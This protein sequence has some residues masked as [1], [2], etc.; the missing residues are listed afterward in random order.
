MTWLICS[1]CLNFLSE[2]WEP[3]TG[4]DEITSVI[5]TQP[6]VHQNIAETLSRDVALAESSFLDQPYTVSAVDVT[7]HGQG[8]GLGRKKRKGRSHDNST[9]KSKKTSDLNESSEREENDQDEK[10]EQETEI[11]VDNMTSNLDITGDSEHIEVPTEILET[12]VKT[13]DGIDDGNKVKVEPESD[14]GEGDNFDDG[15]FSSGDEKAESSFKEDKTPKLEVAEPEKGKKGGLFTEMTEKQ[16]RCILDDKELFTSY[17]PPHDK[18]CKMACVPSE[19]SDQP[20]H[21]PSLIRVFTVRMKK[22]WVL[23]YPLSAQ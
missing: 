7:K 23:S 11:S 20:R 5:D 12:V 8:Q 3:H 19:D 18:T 6:A 21:P 10:M 9:V 14:D 22:A 1:F 2:Q 15:S 17:E 4:R 13:D 16:I